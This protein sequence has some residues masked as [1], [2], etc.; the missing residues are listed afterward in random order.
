MSK[1]MFRKGCVNIEIVT[2]KKVVITMSMDGAD[3]VAHQLDILMGGGTD[4]NELADVSDLYQMLCE[5]TR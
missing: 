3:C 1:E 5:A 2:T 4:N